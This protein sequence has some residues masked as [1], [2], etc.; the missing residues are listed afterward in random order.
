MLSAVEWSP[1]PIRRV[2]KEINM[3]HDGRAGQAR[4]K[5]VTLSHI[6]D[7]RLHGHAHGRW[8]V[9]LAGTVSEIR[10]EVP[11]C[12]LDDRDLA[13]LIAIRAVETGCNVIF[14]ADLLDGGSGVGFEGLR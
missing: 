7:R 12:D 8:P 2:E 4:P 9:S 10:V 13:D 1:R 11:D 6:V 14:D 5:P 3:A